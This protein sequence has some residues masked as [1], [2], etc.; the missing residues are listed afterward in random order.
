MADESGY[1]QR[2]EKLHQGDIMH[3]VPHIR[4][5][6]SP[7]YVL[8]PLDDTKRNFSSNELSKVRFKPDGEQVSA[9]CKI[10]LGIVLT[11]GCNI[12]N[13]PNYRLIAYIRSIESLP[14]EYD[15]G[16]KDSIRKGGNL[17]TMYLPELRGH[18]PESFV[19]F[20]HLTT[21]HPNFLPVEQRVTSLSNERVDEMLT[22]LFRAFT[23]LDLN[24]DMFPL[25]A[26]ENR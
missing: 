19:D 2:D 15:D 5:R 3:G 1:I 6:K 24:D 11:Y 10:D 14:R 17:D 9:H 18:F 13:E 20:R 23:R 4:L 21:L 26:D 12:E 22:R 16:F 25:I 7:L 8:R